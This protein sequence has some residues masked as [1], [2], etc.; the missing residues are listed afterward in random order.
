MFGVVGKKS[1]QIM[2]SKAIAEYNKTAYRAFE[3]QNTV[4][5]I[6]KRIWPGGAESV[7]CRVKII[8]YNL[9]EWSSAIPICR[10]EVIEVS[11]ETLLQNIL[12]HCGIEIE[13]TPKKEAAWTIKRKETV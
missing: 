1:I 4:W 2:I 12:Q 3:H 10:E 11:L 8:P 7:I 9:P 6:G 5:E 13:I